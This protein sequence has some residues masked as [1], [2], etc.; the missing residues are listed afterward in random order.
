VSCKIVNVSAVRCLTLFFSFSGVMYE[1][2]KIDANDV[3]VDGWGA[4]FSIGTLFLM[5]AEWQ[6]HR[7]VSRVGEGV[8]IMPFYFGYHELLD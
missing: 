8:Q 4:L 1:G 6:P 5:V 2:G 7:G 3:D